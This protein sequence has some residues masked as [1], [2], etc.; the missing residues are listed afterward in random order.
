M[1]AWVRFTLRRRWWILAVCAALTALSAWRLS[2]ATIAT[3]LAR[4]FFADIPEYEDY[5][6]RVERFANDEFIAVAFEDSDPFSAASMA[7]LERIVARLRAL[8]EA[9]RVWSLLDV[10]GLVRD[11]EAAAAHP[12][13]GETLISRDGR[14]VAV[15]VELTV[16]PDRPVERVAPLV[17]EAVAAFVAE[18][19]PADGLHRAGLPTVVAEIANQ[20]Y[21]NLMWLFPA[22][23]L[24]LFLIVWA[25]FRHLAPVIVSVVVALLSVIWTMGFT[26]LLD[27]RINIMSSIVPAVVMVVSFSDVIHL[28]SAWRIER[29]AGRSHEDAILAGT[30][31]VGRACL[32]TS[33]TTFVGFVCLSLVPTPVMRQMGL[34]LG[35]GTAVALLLAMTLVPVVLSFVRPASTSS[36]IGDPLLAGLSA[37]TNRRPW[38]VMAAFG[39]LTVLSVAGLTGLKVDTDFERRFREGSRVRRDTAYVREHFAGT[40][41]LEVFVDLERPEDLLDGAVLARVAEFQARVAAAPG[42]TQ[43]WS[44]IDVLRLAPVRDPVAAYALAKLALGAEFSKLVD[45]ERGTLRL[46]VRL[47]SMGVRGIH[48]VGERIEAAAGGLRVE[49][50]GLTHL[51]GW[52]LGAIVAG[53]RNGVL[54][55]L[56]LVTVMMMVGL[57]SWRVGL[58]SMLPNVLPLLAVGGY[59]GAAWDQV[60]S[61]TMIVAMMAI[62]IGVDDTIHFLMRYRVE[63]ARCPDAPEALRRTMAFAG[64]GIIMTTAVLVAGFLPCALSGY[65]SIS[66]LGTLLPGVL[67]VA[68][69][70]DL[71]M[72]PAMVR[73]GWLRYS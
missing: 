43:V 58:L 6:R 73:V 11:A 66:M 48:D 45:E 69:A 10:R 72:V 30:G 70:A 60:D 17:D 38:W 62:G 68:L 57:R 7:R 16:D 46:A 59:V 9:R 50:T 71:L 8:P 15:I 26:A 51:M 42:V 24:V 34:V 2:Q 49:A 53:Q 27:P 56:A 20:T 41:V 19:I 21:F 28:W 39:V 23:S 12:I 1:T 25:L 67:V 52:W 13:I 29:R 40:N 5:R 36:S 54:L 61:D 4:M 33:A 55:S 64:R 44:L 37:L 32:L 65:S 35:F 14:H 47:D 63:S 3:S 18:G 22:T 31:D